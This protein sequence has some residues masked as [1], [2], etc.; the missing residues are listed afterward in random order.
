MCSSYEAVSVKLHLNV[1]SSQDWLLFSSGD[2]GMRH[3]QKGNEGHITRCTVPHVTI[4]KAN[5]QW[6]YFVCE[7][8]QKYVQ[9]RQSHDQKIPGPTSFFSSP[10]ICFFYDFYSYLVIDYACVDHGTCSGIFFSLLTLSDG[11]ACVCW[12]SESAYL[13]PSS[14]PSHPLLH[15]LHSIEDIF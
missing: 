7:M 11:A 14:L 3:N 13:L 6:F 2:L 8:W 1:V 15:T 12:V 10:W 5:E 4:I 9:T